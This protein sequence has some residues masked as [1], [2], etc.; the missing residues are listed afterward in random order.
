MPRPSPSRF[1]PRTTFGKEYRSLSSSLCNFLHSPVTSSLLGPNTL[2][3]T[4]FSNTLSRAIPLLSLRAFVVAYER[5][6]PTY[7][8]TYIPIFR[9]PYL[10]SKQYEPF[11]RSLVYT[12][13]VHA[14]FMRPSEHGLNT[15]NRAFN[16]I[17]VRRLTLVLNLK[18]P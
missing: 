15:R 7:L 8:Q 12:T 3:N 1:N 2:L 9:I 18:T 16:I 6:K 4:L 13:L 14:D 11:C 17:D 5:V 10:C